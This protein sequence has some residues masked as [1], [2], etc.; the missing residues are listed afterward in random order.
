MEYVISV[1]Q[2]ITTSVFNSCGIIIII[3]LRCVIKDDENFAFLR[4]GDRIDRSKTDRWSSYLSS[5]DL[6]MVFTHKSFSLILPSPE[7][8]TRGCCHMHP[9][10]V[11]LQK[12]RTFQFRCSFISSMSRIWNQLLQLFFSFQIFG[13]SNPV[14]R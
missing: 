1:S 6:F 11:Q 4:P 2:L 13:C 9:Y 8:P 14:S 10:T 12:P 3:I 7:R 5:T